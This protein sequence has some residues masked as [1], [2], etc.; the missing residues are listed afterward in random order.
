MCAIEDVSGQ[1]LLLRHDEK[2]PYLIGGKCSFCEAVFFPK[3]LICPRC[4][5]RNVMETA[6]SRKGKLYTYTEVYQQPPDYQGSVPY[7]IGRVLLPEG[8]FVLA[9]LKAKK[10]DLRVNM[11]MELVIESIFRDDSGKDFMAYKFQPV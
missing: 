10:E 4:T 7:L 8:V 2:D 5:G 11:D 3:Q 6:L 9:Q 1:A